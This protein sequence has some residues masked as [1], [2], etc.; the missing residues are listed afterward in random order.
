MFIISPEFKFVKF[1]TA[2]SVRFCR[3]PNPPPY[4]VIRIQERKARET[5][6]V[7]NGKPNN[8]ALRA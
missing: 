1:F 2:V 6:K 3:Y 5:E 8:G 7:E 4:P